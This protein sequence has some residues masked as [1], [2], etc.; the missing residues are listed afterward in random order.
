MPDDE[1]V[2][3]WFPLIG[4]DQL[5]RRV[6]VTLKRPEDRPSSHR[7]RVEDA[8][9]IFGAASDDGDLTLR[10]EGVRG[11]GETVVVVRGQD[12]RPPHAR[13][14]QHL[15]RNRW[16]WPVREECLSERGLERASLAGLE[17]AHG[18]VST[19]YQLVARH[20]LW[21]RRHRIASDRGFEPM[22]KGPPVGADRDA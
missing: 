21:I 19:P 7:Q 2:A 17:R 13:E 3:K 6:E 4:A 5:I 11:S 18:G 22:D 14:R 15:R 1:L 20:I 12:Q 16:R 8:L 9:A 10:D